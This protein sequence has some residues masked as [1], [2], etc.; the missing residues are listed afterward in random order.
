MFHMLH[1]HL[2][3]LFIHVV[4]PFWLLCMYQLHTP[5]CRSIASHP[6]CM[7]NIFNLVHLS[8]SSFE[9]HLPNFTYNTSPLFFVNALTYA[10]K[11]TLR[12]DCKTNRSHMT[13]ANITFSCQTSS[14]NDLQENMLSS[15]YDHLRNF[16]PFGIFTSII[17]VIG[18]VSWP[19]PYTRMTPFQILPN[20]SLN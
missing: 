16:P 7:S 10:E 17:L 20:Q 1:D 3:S 15:S 4:C 2:Q 19:L 12:D 9:V 5:S 13:T 14:S 11:K 8:Y 18:Y 6:P